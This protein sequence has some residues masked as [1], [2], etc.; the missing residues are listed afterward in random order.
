MKYSEETERP[1]G[2]QK[3]YVLGMMGG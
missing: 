2:D 1:K 3:G